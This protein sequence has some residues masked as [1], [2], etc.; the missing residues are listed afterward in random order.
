MN[1]DNVVI[2]MSVC[3]FLENDWLHEMMWVKRPLTHNT[4]SSTII[5]L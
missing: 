3:V 2:V 4:T 5:R 1:S